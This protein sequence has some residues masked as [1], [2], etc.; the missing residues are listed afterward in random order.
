[1]ST[2][3]S[4]WWMLYSGAERCKFERREDWI[5]PL[6]GDGKAW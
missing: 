6:L 5:D 3:E 4:I 1:M 2:Y